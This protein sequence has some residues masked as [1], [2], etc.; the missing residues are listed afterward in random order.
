MQKAVERALKNKERRLNEKRD[1]HGRV[2]DN[3]PYE[4]RK[5]TILSI[6]KLSDVTSMR[7]EMFQGHEVIAFDFEPK[8][9]VKPK[10]RIETIITKLA[11]TMWVDEEAQQIAR[12]EA[13]L[14]DSFKLAGG[15]FAKVAPSTAVVL[16]QAKIG[17]EVWMPSYAEANL[18]ARIML[19]A[20]FNRSVTTRYSDY[21]KYSIDNRYELSKPK[22]DKP[23]EK[24][25][26]DKQ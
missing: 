18:A 8:K 14:I 6:L 12:V 13:R 5:V 9:G 20:K 26:N 1:G 21:K 17:D 7:R 25:T 4:D 11:G 16:E 2:N 22:S 24:T 10:N 15:L 23:V 3:D 19:F